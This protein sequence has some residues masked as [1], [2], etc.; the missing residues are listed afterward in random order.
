MSAHTSTYSANRMAKNSISSQ[1]A[2]FYRNI[3]SACK[4]LLYK[5]RHK[6]DLWTESFLMPWQKAD[7]FVCCACKH[8]VFSRAI[9]KHH[10][11]GTYSLIPN[12]F[13]VF[14]SISLVLTILLATNF[15]FINFS[16]SKS[17]TLI[18]FFILF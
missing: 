18:D 10:N 17:P 5:L 16:C 1:F 6:A 9:G 8:S 3:I 7:S 15:T 12:I 11:E 14:K 2:E 13:F 4:P